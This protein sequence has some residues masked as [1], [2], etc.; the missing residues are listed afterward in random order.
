M[1][2][3]VYANH[4]INQERVTLDTLTFD[5][6]VP[7]NSC[8]YSACDDTSGKIVHVAFSRYA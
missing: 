7:A 5:N 1:L 8:S 4:N 3:K 6:L 2:M